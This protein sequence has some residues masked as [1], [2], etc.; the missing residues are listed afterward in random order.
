LDRPLPRIKGYLAT[1]STLPEN[2][3]F[4]FWTSTD[5]TDDAKALIARIKAQHKR[6]PITFYNGVQTRERLREK[7]Q[8]SL[9]DIFDEQFRLR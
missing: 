3:S 8:S 9:V 1:S 2:K 7:K 4:E 6:Q 5:Y